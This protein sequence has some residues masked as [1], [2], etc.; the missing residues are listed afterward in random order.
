MY[1]NFFILLFGIVI[2]G[3][4]FF[5]YPSKEGF[6]TAHSAQVQ[7]SSTYA[8]NSPSLPPNVY[9]IESDT[10]NNQDNLPWIM[11]VSGFSLI[12]EVKQSI[13]SIITDWRNF[14]GYLDRRATWKITDSS[15]LQK[16]PLPYTTWPLTTIDYFGKYTTTNMDYSDIHTI[17]TFTNKVAGGTAIKMDTDTLLYFNAIED[18][19]GFWGPRGNSSVD[20]MVHNANSVV[21]GTNRTD[22]NTISEGEYQTN[23]N[24]YVSLINSNKASQ[25]RKVLLGQVPWNITPLSNKVQNTY[26]D[27]SPWSI[28][29]NTTFGGTTKLQLQIAQTLREDEQSPYHDLGVFAGNLYVHTGYGYLTDE[30]NFNNN[31]IDVEVQNTNLSNARNEVLRVYMYGNSYSNVAVPLCDYHI[32]DFKKCTIWGSIFNFHDP[33]VMDMYLNVPFDDSNLNGSKVYYSFGFFLPDMVATTGSFTFQANLEGL[34]Y[35]TY[36]RNLKNTTT[37][38]IIIPSNT[39]IQYDSSIANI[40]FLTGPTTPW[41]TASTA[42]TNA[43]PKPT[44]DSAS[45]VIYYNSLKSQGVGSVQAISDS[46][47]EK[48]IVGLM[49]PQILSYMPKYSSRYITSW[50][51]NRAQ[52]VLTNA[53]QDTNKYPNNIDQASF[54]MSL[55]YNNYTLAQQNGNTSNM[56]NWSN[57]LN[58]YLYG[59]STATGIK[60]ITT[61]HTLNYNM[62]GAVNTNGNYTN[63]SANTINPQI[64]ALAHAIYIKNNGEYTLT[65]DNKFTLYS[66]SSAYIPD[67]NCTSYQ[68]S[69]PSGSN[70]NLSYKTT[71]D[72]WDLTSA[73]ITSMTTDYKYC[74][75]KLIPDNGVASN[76]NLVDPRLLNYI[77]QNFYTMTD[78]LYHIVEI[79]D[80]FLIGSN[81]LDVRFDKQ[82]LLQKGDYIT[83]RDQYRPAL[84]YYNSLVYMADQNSW[85]TTYSNITDFQTDLSNAYGALEPIFNPVYTLC[86]LNPNYIKAQITELLAE[87]IIYSNSIQSNLGVTAQTSVI[88]GTQIFGGVNYTVLDTSVLTR[89]LTANEAATYQAI[90]TSNLNTLNSLSNQLNGIETNVARIFFTFHPDNKKGSNEVISSMCNGNIHLTNGILLSNQM[91][92]SDGVNITYSNVAVGTFFMNNIALGLNAALSFNTAYSSGLQIDMGQSLGNLNYA[93]SIIYNCNAI[94]PIDC[95][96]VNFMKEAAQMYMDGIFVGLSTFTS[97]IFHDSNG[98]VRVDKIFNFTQI[99]DSTCGFNWQESQYD[100]YT[101]E[102]VIR[103]TVNVQIP[104][105]YDNTQ[106]QDPLILIDTSGSSIYLSKSLNNSTTNPVYSFD[107]DYMNLLYSKLSNYTDNLLITT[108]MISSMCSNFLVGSVNHMCSINNPSYCTNQLSSSG[109]VFTLGLQASPTCTDNAKCSYSNLQTA[110]VNAFSNNVLQF[111]NYYNTTPLLIGGTFNDIITKLWP[112]YN[113]Q[114]V[115]SNP[116]YIQTYGAPLLKAT[117]FNDAPSL[118]YE[119]ELCVNKT[120]MLFHLFGTGIQFIR[121]DVGFSTEGYNILMSQ[122]N[123]FVEDI[124]VINKEIGTILIGNDINNGA[125]LID[126]D[127]SQ[128]FLSSWDGACP[129]NVSCTDPTVM[130]QIMDY[131]NLSGLNSNVITRIMKGFTPNPYQCD[132][133]LEFA[134]SNGVTTQG[135]MRFEVAPDIDT[136]QYMITSNTALNTGYYIQDTIPQERVSDSSGAFGLGF[137]YIGN[138]LQNYMY[139][140]SN[141][142]NPYIYYASNSAEEMLKA[143][144]KSRNSTYDALGKMNNITIF[145]TVSNCPN[146][147]DTTLL[148][149]MFQNNQ[150]FSQTFFTAYPYLDSYMKNIVRFGISSNTITVVYERDNYIVQNNQCVYTTT[151]TAAAIYSIDITPDY[152]DFTASFVQGSLPLPPSQYRNM[153]NIP[154]YAYTSSNEYL[155]ISD[156]VNIPNPNPYYQIR[157]NNKKYIYDTLNSLGWLTNNGYV[158]LKI[159]LVSPQETKIGLYNPITSSNIY[160][161]PYLLRNII[162]NST[163]FIHSI[164]D[165]NTII[166][167]SEFTSNDN[168][169]EFDILMDT[170]NIDLGN[171]L[172][173]PYDNI[174]TG[175]TNIV[176]YNANNEICDYMIYVEDNVPIYKQFYRARFYNNNMFNESCSNI[177]IYSLTRVNDLEQSLFAYVPDPNDQSLMEMFHSY[178]NSMNS[179]ANYNA[180]N[181]IIGRIYTSDLSGNNIIYSASVF[182][183]DSNNNYAALLVPHATYFD[184]LM[185]FSV[186][187]FEQPSTGSITILNMNEIQPIQGFQGTPVVDSNALTTTPTQDFYQ[188]FICLPD[189]SD[190]NLLNVV[191]NSI[192]QVL[193]NNLLNDTYSI[194]YMCAI[195]YGKQNT[196]FSY[197]Y[198]VNTNY[199][200]YISYTNSN[201]YVNTQTDPGTPTIHYNPVIIPESVTIDQA[202]EAYAT[203]NVVSSSFSNVVLRLQFNITPITVAEIV[204]NC[205]LDFS[206]IIKPTTFVLTNTLI[207]NQSYISTSNYL[208]IS[209]SNIQSIHNYNKQ[210]STS[211][212]KFTASQNIDTLCSFDYTDQD[213]I[214]HIKNN[215]F[216]DLLSNISL[217]V[218]FS[219]FQSIGL[220][221]TPNILSGKNDTSDP[222]TFH[223]IITLNAITKTSPHTTISYNAVISVKLYYYNDRNQSTPNHIFYSGNSSNFFCTTY[224]TSI[225]VNSILDSSINVG[226]YAN[227]NLFKPILTISPFENY[228]SKKKY[229]HV[230]FESVNY[231]IDSLQLFNKKKQSI[232]IKLIEQNRTQYIYEFEPSELVGYSFITNNTSSQYDPKEWILKGIYGKQMDILDKRRIDDVP[233]LHQMPLFF[234]DGTEEEL[235]QP[236]SYKIFTEVSI[237]KSIFMKY[238]KEKIDKNSV[239][240]FKKYRKEKDTYYIVY[241]EYDQNK[242][243]VE[244]N[245]IIGF[246]VKDGKVIKAILYID[247]DGNYKPFNLENPKEKKFWDIN[248]MVPLLFEEI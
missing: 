66:N 218:S 61:T 104:F 166:R 121:G 149:S 115:L 123:G 151:D 111:D 162:E 235:D 22:T 219:S 74:T 87:N 158:L 197:D 194:D 48:Q 102:P 33:N 36:I 200:R 14:S 167:T 113:S 47:I 70:P 146:T 101:N 247:A 52:R 226:V 205:T 242:T 209:Y 185:F 50:S 18:W 13:I 144:Y 120:G 170:L 135:S 206:S 9:L 172:T 32:A 77:A 99:N 24:K 190:I 95:T 11:D 112:I 89:N 91:P 160:S 136:C 3:L 65:T 43:T 5:F 138:K 215:D 199:R 244:Q 119:I 107:S 98:T 229:S 35:N 12:Y 93:P 237:D 220:G 76:I 88:S 238:Y 236:K 178:Y 131:Y 31:P 189:V 139:A 214:Q 213:F 141:V 105:T 188:T 81:M 184:N 147:L 114:L 134:S 23:F 80:I 109:N 227:N 51:Y 159:Q 175:L 125:L 38:T 183:T 230:I 53:I 150:R 207:A 64:D 145:N 243:L 97:N 126:Y 40:R 212:S 208:P 58:I 165:S 57:Y 153:S 129:T 108:N 106:Y 4:I 211:F 173:I 133:Y 56:S 176:S 96:N 67:N 30:I 85:G 2:L 130:E 116:Y 110:I 142:V 202:A 148:T 174:Y 164:I 239:P 82:Q 157:L 161:S 179:I 60:Y 10:F 241:D 39:D 19:D 234:F 83:L 46:N 171:C 168:H 180:F 117:K 68:L 6:G 132:Y 54:L 143:F 210:N 84:D 232:G 17:M 216:S 27:T 177:E 103:R 196:D 154:P 78:G 71:G 152:C 193:S 217:T 203:N 163:P 79:Y 195:T 187:F 29:L 45:N 37:N 21:P 137:Q 201:P 140:V 25:E 42:V 169:L 186:L 155:F 122:S 245:N 90:I 62:T 28:P 34:N 1:R 228:V 69:T 100:Y 63:H 92:F 156:D 7:E 49:T 59:V 118:A 75:E 86:N 16:T 248:I 192:G 221:P 231:T 222:L 94:L 44:T 8:N 233:R 240:L 20:S 191:S 15:T 204:N 127:I 128:T 225:T 124:K 224:K 198:I 72:T 181:S 246:T 26:T 55:A 73:T 223:Y 41:N 182:Y